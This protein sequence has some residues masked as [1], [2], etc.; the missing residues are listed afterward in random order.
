MMAGNIRVEIR[1][2]M[3]VSSSSRFSDIILQGAGKEEPGARHQ[4]GIFIPP[5]IRSRGI[6]IKPDRK[7]AAPARAH[8]VRHAAQS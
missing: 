5:P 6:P 7:M 2:V 4:P 3:S 1:S 8:A